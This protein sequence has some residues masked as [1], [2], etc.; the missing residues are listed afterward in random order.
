[1]VKS[2]RDLEVWKKAM[3]FAVHVYKVQRSFPETERFGLADQL[4]RAVVSIPSN[5]AEGRGRGS[6][7]DFVRFLYQAQGS[8]NEVFT[9]L[10][11]ACRLGIVSHG[12]GLYDEATEI[13]RMLSSMIK[14]LREHPQP[15][16]ATPSNPTPQIQPLKAKS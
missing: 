9:Q 5:I 12:T 8:L 13:A 14:R 15:L 2:F 1:M 16:K 10:E 3:D 4:R 6:A 7:K 11:L